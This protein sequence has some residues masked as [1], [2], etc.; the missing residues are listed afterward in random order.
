MPGL[1]V[2]SSAPEFKLSRHQGR[3]FTRADL[4]G[5]TTVLVFYPFAFSPVCTEQLAVYNEVL[6]DLTQEGATLYGVSCDA[7]WAQQA[8]KAQ[9]RLD[10]EQLSDFHP[11]GSAS[12]AFGV[13]DPGGFPKRALLLFGPDAVLRWSHVSASADDVPGANLIFDALAA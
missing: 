13:M 1:A 5:R 3:A 10:I 12:D 2:G 11:K 4:L 8:F 6:E 9:L 7:T